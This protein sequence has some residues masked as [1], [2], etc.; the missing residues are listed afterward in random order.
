M[1]TTAGSDLLVSVGIVNCS[2]IFPI[3]LVLL[4][5]SFQ[6]SPTCPGTAV[7]WRAKGLAH[8]LV[9]H[10]PC[11][12]CVSKLAQARLVSVSARV[13]V[14][15]GTVRVRLASRGRSVISHLAQRPR[16]SSKIETAIYTT[17]PAGCPRILFL[18]RTASLIKDPLPPKQTRP[19]NTCWRFLS[20]PLLDQH[21]HKLFALLCPS[22]YT[23]RLSLW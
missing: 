12:S 1:K 10:L 17:D 15:H 4:S 21:R 7:F 6:H 2:R 16:P 23:A 5:D 14:V 20:A 9:R 18:R 11:Q 3:S 13:S 19:S 8:A 22:R